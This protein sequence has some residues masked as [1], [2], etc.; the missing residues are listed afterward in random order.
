MMR[1]IS[2][3]DPDLGHQGE[4]EGENFPDEG[5]NSIKEEIQQEQQ[6]LKTNGSN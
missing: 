5:E 6:S 3:W 2:S 4:S 1:K